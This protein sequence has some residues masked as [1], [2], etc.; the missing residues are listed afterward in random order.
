MRALRRLLPVLGAIL[1]VACVTA[2]PLPPLTPIPRDEMIGMSEVVGSQAAFERWLQADVA[3]TQSF[4]RF[5]A[6]LQ[7]QGVSNVVPNFQLWRSDQIDPVCATSGF[8]EP[9][10]RDWANIVATLRILRDE[11]IPTVGPLNVE[12]GYRDPAFNACIHGAQR[13]AHV[14]FEALD[15]TPVNR[16]VTRELLIA[17]LCPLHAREG[18]RLQMGLGVYAGRR[19]HV[20]AR[21]YRGWGPDYHRT[22]FPCAAD[23]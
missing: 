21:S 7:R 12:S 8:V 23:E 1:A 2:R 22:T 5:E 4:A 13:S 20:D 9:P 3:R 15:I 6:A 19:F 14:G 16:A 17:M 18:A 11:V 10:E